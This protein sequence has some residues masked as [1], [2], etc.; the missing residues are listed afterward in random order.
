MHKVKPIEF[1]DIIQNVDS[2]VF[3]WNTSHVGLVTASKCH[4]GTISLCSKALSQTQDTM[5]F[6]EK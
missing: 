6:G 2:I 4:R 1:Q 3:L 5:L